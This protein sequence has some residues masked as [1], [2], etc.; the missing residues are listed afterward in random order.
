MILEGASVKVPRGPTCAEV[1]GAMSD[2]LAD[3]IKKVIT[4]FKSHYSAG[5]KS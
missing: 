1:A 2:D 3:K 5:E 4:D